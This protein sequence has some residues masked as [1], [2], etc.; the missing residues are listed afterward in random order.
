MELVRAVRAHR[1]GFVRPAASAFLHVGASVAGAGYRCAEQAH[2]HAGGRV[3]LP[4]TVTV[5]GGAGRAAR[6]PLGG[7]VLS[8]RK[9]R[10]EMGWARGAAP[11]SNPGLRL[12]GTK[13][14]VLRSLPRSGNAWR[15]GT[16][17]RG[18]CGGCSCSWRLR[19]GSL[20]AMHR[21]APETCCPL[22]HGEK[23]LRSLR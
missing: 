7:G 4:P 9:G 14:A 18:L 3:A 16:K 17:R 8:D 19:S 1:F 11:G 6:R 20:Q 10:K 5:D 23:G 2:P 21:A 12:R 22:D 13:E 15:E